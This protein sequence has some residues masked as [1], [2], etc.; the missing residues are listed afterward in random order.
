MSGD[1]IYVIEFFPQ[2][3]KEHY[4][5]WSH[6][7]YMVEMFMKQHYLDDSK[8]R[9]IVFPWEELEDHLDEVREEYLLDR[10]LMGS[11]DTGIIYT[12]ITSDEFIELALNNLC[13]ALTSM[14]TFGPCALRGDLE[15]ID[16]IIRLINDLPY[17][18]VYDGE[19]AEESDDPDCENVDYSYTYDGVFTIRNPDTVLVLTV[20]SYIRTFTNTLLMGDR[21]PVVEPKGGK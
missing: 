15:A 21:L 18:Y 3:S 20:E 16:E 1:M 8:V 13:D 7:K 2:R 4:Y 17:T 12:I 9:W 11:N 14:L 5:V 6:Q 19:I 10:Y